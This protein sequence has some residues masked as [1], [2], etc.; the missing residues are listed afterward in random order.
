MCEMRNTCNI[1]KK[2]A[3]FLQLL[4]SNSRLHTYKTKLDNGCFCMWEATA[5][6]GVRGF[7]TVQTVEY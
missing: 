3:T 5:V 7:K 2:I 6:N 4:W 1:Y